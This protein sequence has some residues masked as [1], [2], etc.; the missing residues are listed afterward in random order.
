MISNYSIATLL[1]AVLAFL[2]ALLGSAGAAATARTGGPDVTALDPG[3]WLESLI[4]ALTAGLALLHKPQ[5]KDETN[6]TATAAKQITDVVAN[7][8]LAHED[9]VKQAIEGIQAVQQA[10]GDLTKLLPGQFTNK[11]AQNTVSTAESA[12][13][14]DAQAA[15]NALGMGPLAKQVIGQVPRF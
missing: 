8:A 11:A 10:T 12:I 14:T 3:A 13:L 15:A 4:P 9:L 5:T 1:K 2:V 6:P 7:A